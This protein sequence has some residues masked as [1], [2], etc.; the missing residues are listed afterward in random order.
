MLM[1]LVHA[2]HI[3]YQEKL[4]ND[5]ILMD[6]DMFATRPEQLDTVPKPW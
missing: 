1:L 4:G 5:I 6:K 2:L 3:E